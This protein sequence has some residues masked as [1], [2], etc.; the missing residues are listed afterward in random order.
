MIVTNPI[1]SFVLIFNLQLFG[2]GQHAIVKY[3]SKIKKINDYQSMRVTFIFSYNL[4][5]YDDYSTVEILGKN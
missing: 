3:F 5:N 2:I 4:M 1:T